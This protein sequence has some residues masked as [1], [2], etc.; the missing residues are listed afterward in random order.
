MN[1]LILVNRNNLLDRTYI[2]NDLVNGDSIYKD[3]ILVSKQVKRVFHIMQEDA[4]LNGYNIDIMSGYR[5]YDYQDKIYNK[6][7]HDKGFNYAFR[8]IAPPG[9]SEHQT[10]LAIDICVYRDD[11]CYIEHEI[12]DFEEIKWVLN[13]CYK[14]GFILRYPLNKEDVTGYN[15]EAWH[16]RYVGKLAPY[17]YFNNLTLE[18][19]YQKNNFRRILSKNL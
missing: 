5:S 3:N 18:E 4:R 10:G 7:I 19:Y 6:L 2:P 12:V 16:F 15:Y 9:G 14:Y 8:H 1:Y 11:R 17:L 13:N